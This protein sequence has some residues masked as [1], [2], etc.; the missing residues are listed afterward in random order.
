MA[1]RLKLMVAKPK[2]ASLL[3][4]YRQTTT[5]LPTVLMRPHSRDKP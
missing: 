4:H 3:P 1:R 2:I 5:A